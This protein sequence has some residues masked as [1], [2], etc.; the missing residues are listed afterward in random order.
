MNEIEIIKT[1]SSP[2]RWAG[3][4]KTLMKDLFT[5]IPKDKEI[6]VEPFLGSGTVLLNIL[7]NQDKFR[8]ADYYVNDKNNCIITFFKK[9]KYDRNNLIELICKEV[10]KYNSLSLEE[11]EEYYYEKREEFNNRNNTNQLMN[12]VNFYI[13]MKTCFNGVF[14]VN[15][16]NKY[17][18]P[19][20]KKE[21]IANPTEQLI[22][23]SKLIKNV[24]F[25]NSDYQLF[26][27]TVIKK[28][29]IKNSFVYCDPPYIPEDDAVYKKQNMY[30]KYEFNHVY[31]C[32]IIRRYGKKAKICIS[33]SDSSKSNE[34]YGADFKKTLVNQVNRKVNPN[35]NKQSLEIVFTN[36]L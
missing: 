18:V 7:F 9:L 16:D 26:L 4:K 28:C 33:M 25:Y 20:G 22:V 21:K 35:K 11:K 15:G 2:I 8:F 34:I 31:F 14:R 36:Y 29:N 24:H 5:Y 32:K 1:I 6:Y 27:E 13:L 12:S 30:S 10:N 17:N 19:F 3:S 23:I